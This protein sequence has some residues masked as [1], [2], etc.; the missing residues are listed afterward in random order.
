MTTGKTIA[1]T[2]W[3]FI[4]KVM[5]LL[6]NTLSRFLYKCP[7]VWHLCHLSLKDFLEIS[8]HLA[9]KLFMKYLCFLYNEY[10]SSCSTCSYIGRGY[11]SLYMFTYL[12]SWS[13]V[14]QL[15]LFFFFNFI[16]LY[17][18]VLVLPHI[19]MNPPW[20]YMCSQSWTPLQPPS[21]YHPSALKALDV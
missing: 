1:L 4:G 17:N 14:Y 7:F 13:K 18:T 11:L 20:V 16:L 2:R 8:G 3:T 10:I 5:S 12:Y 21:P 9:R 6:F 19:N 15:W